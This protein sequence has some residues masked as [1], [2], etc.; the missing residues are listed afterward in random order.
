M[1]DA[2]FRAADE[3]SRTF[4]R[5]AIERFLDRSWILDRT[6]L[7][8]LHGHR[9][10][11]NVLD[12]WLQRNRVVTLTAASSSDVRALLNSRHWDA[13]SRRCEALLGL[14]TRFYQSLKDCK[15][16]LDD[17]IEMLIDQELAAQARKRK[18]ARPAL[19][20]R[21]GRK[22]LFTRAPSI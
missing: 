20:E 19:R 11:L 12:D 3:G 13:V 21:P 18:A 6:P 15:H 7:Q 17:P 10:A 16:R 5:D 14:I 4:C 9:A 22:Y 2:R 1:T 8:A